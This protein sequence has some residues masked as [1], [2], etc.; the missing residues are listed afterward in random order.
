MYHAL[1]VPP[2]LE[3]RDRQDRPLKLTEG[4]PLVTLF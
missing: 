4:Q 3:V 2:D 1:G